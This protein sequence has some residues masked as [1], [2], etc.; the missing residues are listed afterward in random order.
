MAKNQTQLVSLAPGTTL[1]TVSSEVS[2]DGE[3][4]YQAEPAFALVY[5]SDDDNVVIGLLDHEFPLGVHK[6]YGVARANTLV[7]VGITPEQLEQHVAATFRNL[8]GEANP[9]P[10]PFPLAQPAQDGA[11]PSSRLDER[12]P[13]PEFAD[14]PVGRPS[15]SS[16]LDDEPVQ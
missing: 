13:P 9:M 8:F 4:S 10:P 2:P 1:L 15:N 6:R 12:P 11:A 7:P 5:N 3:I 14:I 16:P